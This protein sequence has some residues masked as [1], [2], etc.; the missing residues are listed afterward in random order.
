MPTVR[1]ETYINAGAERCFDLS[2]SIDIH[3]GSLAHTKERAIAGVTSGLL[4]LHDTV[5]WEAVHFGVR[6][7]L[8]SKVTEFERPN[9]FTDEM[10]RGPLKRM[11]HVHEFI[12][13]GSG[14]LM[15][16]TFTFESRLSVLGR[17]ADE[18]VLVGYV[19]RLLM[20][21]N[22]YIK[23]VGEQESDQKRQ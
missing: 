23:R 9:R 16:D 4:G 10:V 2:R 13:Q 20:A 22:A 3:L 15:S 17:L 5:T 6:H 18:L 8:T 12:P 1:L 14:T 21:R 19:R 11:K 7:R